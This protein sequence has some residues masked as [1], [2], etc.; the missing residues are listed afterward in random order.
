M[1]LKKGKSKADFEYNLT[2]LMRSG[3]EKDQALAIAYSKK[4][5]KKKKKGD[6]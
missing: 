6:K 1:P 4:G 5:E 3:Y 2:E